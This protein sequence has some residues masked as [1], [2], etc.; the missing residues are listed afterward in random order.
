MDLMHSGDGV[1]LSFATGE[2]G[3]ETWAGVS[4]DAFAAAN[5]GIGLL[6]SRG[7]QYTVTTGG[8]K[9]CVYLL[10]DVWC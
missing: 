5:I 4:A 10:F 1:R 7:F 9:R 3:S 6:N 2:C 8:K